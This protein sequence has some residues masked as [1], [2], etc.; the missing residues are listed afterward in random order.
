MRSLLLLPVVLGLGAC[1]ST[2]TGPSP[3]QEKYVEG[4]QVFMAGEP[5]TR[6]YA[7]IMKVMGMNCS[8]APVGARVWGN[9]SLALN[10]MKTR[11]K[12][13]GAEVVVDASC[14]VV[15]V[16]ANCWAAVK[17]TGTAVKWAE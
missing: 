15:P 1:A 5:V 7:P 2:P 14:E 11:A 17:C 10:E 4:I 9:R 12:H 8:G 13:A 16:L 6:S 3:N